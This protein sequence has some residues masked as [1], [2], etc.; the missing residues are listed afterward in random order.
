VI[1]VAS[2][3]GPIAV[4][5]EI[6]MS[7]FKGTYI[8][9]DEMKRDEA[10]EMGYDNVGSHPRHIGVPEVGDLLVIDFDHILFDDRI[11]AVQAAVEHARRGVRVG[12][13]TYAPDDP[14]LEPVHAEPGIKVGK[15][16]Q[17]VL[18]TLGIPSPVPSSQ[19]AAAAPDASKSLASLTDAE[20]LLFWLE[21]AQ[22]EIEGQ[23]T[24]ERSPAT[25]L[26]SWD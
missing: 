12:I 2:P 26:K 20:A 7:M 11:E 14:R 19:P 22:T 4:G 25:D 13:H 16:H 1:T 24:V 3:D 8:S 5:K 10:R 15:T 9:S 23:Q 6:I 17:D 21:A 18:A